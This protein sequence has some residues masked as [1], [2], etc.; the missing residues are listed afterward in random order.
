MF[1]KNIKKIRSVK[2][3]SQQA[4]ADL[5][6]LKRG[7]LA[8]YEEGRSNPRVETVIKIAAHFQL[9]TDDLLKNELTVNKLL[10]FND[11]LTTQAN[12]LPVQQFATIPCIVQAAESEFIRLQGSS[13]ACKRLPTLQL[14]LPDGKQYIGYQVHSAEMGLPGG[15]GFLPRDVAI[16]KKID[17]PAL[18][19]LPPGS[20]VLVLTTDA[21]YF[22]KMTVTP[23][24]LLLKTALEGIDPV[25][26]PLAAIVQAW[27]IQHAFMWKVPGM[28]SPL[29]E[30]LAQLEQKLLQ[31][32]QDS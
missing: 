14:P 19:Q 26:I 28:Q 24:G 12:T 25:E 2:G 3:L 11:N 20:V 8:A 23:N 27:Q 1:G 30:R 4:F 16:G 5:F 22:K 31:L 15:G 17:T 9:E 7:T 18:L 13:P 6:G 21:L 29:E 32:G 10:Q